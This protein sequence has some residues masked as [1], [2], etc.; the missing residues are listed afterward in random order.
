[1]FSLFKVCQLVYLLTF[2]QPCSAP[3]S[4]QR[5]SRASCCPQE[6]ETLG[7]FWKRRVTSEPDGEDLRKRRH[8]SSSEVWWQTQFSGGTEFKLYLWLAKSR[9]SLF[10]FKPHR[11]WV[12]QSGS[13]CK[14]PPTFLLKPRPHQ[15]CDLCVLLPVFQAALGLTAARSPGDG[16]TTLSSWWVFTQEGEDSL[17]GSQE[18]GEKKEC[19]S[20]GHHQGNRSNSPWEPQYRRTMGSPRLRLSPRSMTCAGYSH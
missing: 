12:S 19:V 16:I 6:S 10:V 20:A 1:M 13:S 8:L 15:I 18:G 4:C 17:L 5:G 7:V 14:T 3:T 9:F 11:C 2:S